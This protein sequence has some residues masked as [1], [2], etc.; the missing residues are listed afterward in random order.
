M[1]SLTLVQLG[2]ETQLKQHGDN[3]H[4]LFTGVNNDRRR[5]AMANLSLHSLT[6]HN[7][8]GKPHCPPRGFNSNIT[9]IPAWAMAMLEIA[10]TCQLG[11]VPLFD[12]CNGFLG[13]HH[14][15]TPAAS[16]R[17]LHMHCLALAIVCCRTL[18]CAS[19]ACTHASSHSHSP[20][21]A[22]FSFMSLCL[23]LC[24]HKFHKLPSKLALEKRVKS[25][26]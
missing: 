7:C 14:T 20:S 10:A 26:D 17:A 1:P 18:V 22:F 6:V 21:D 9:H 11:A 23:L 25:L 12:I 19:Y 2:C 16:H 8:S 24:I 13:N 3:S 4:P 15:R 5:R